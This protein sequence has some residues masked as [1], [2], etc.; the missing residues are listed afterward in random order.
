MHKNLQF[1]HMR[2]K[3]HSD[4]DV[5]KNDVTHTK[6][7]FLPKLRVLINFIKLMTYLDCFLGQNIPGYK[8]SLK[9]WS[10]FKEKINTYINIKIVYKQAII[11]Y[12]YIYIYLCIFFS[13]TAPNFFGK[14]GILGYSRIKKDLD[15]SKV[16]E[17]S[18]RALILVFANESCIMLV[19]HIS[20]SY[21]TI[22]D[23]I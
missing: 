6:Y 3:R 17:N 20:I 11:V 16:W 19:H 2:W 13:K 1:F 9:K 14:I 21:K 15:R 10:R 22:Y 18:L 7:F 8:F 12:I 23:I 5:Y 4:S